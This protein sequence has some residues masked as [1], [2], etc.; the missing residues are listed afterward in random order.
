[1]HFLVQH[2][3]F[4]TLSGE[5]GTCFKQ[6]K[7]L[8]ELTSAH[9][10]LMEKTKMSELISTRSTFRISMKIYQ[11]ENSLS[12]ILTPVLNIIRQLLK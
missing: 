5:Y 8:N 6:S 12:L 9:Y 2:C 11:V 1:M 10:I 4:I 7:N 3:T